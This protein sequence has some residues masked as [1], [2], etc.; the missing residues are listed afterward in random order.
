M[1]SPT[2][3]TDV[4]AGLR[5]SEE[6]FR[7][8]VQASSDMV[9]RMNPDWT[10]MHQLAGRD[11]IVNTD[12]PDRTWL[13]KY[14]HPDDQP[15]VM[16]G[17]EEAIRSKSVF[18]LVH[19][20]LRVDGSLGWT[21]SRAIPMLG[22]DG[23]IVEWIGMARDIT[24]RK[25]AKEASAR[26]RDLLQSVMNSAG[27]AHLVCLDLDF[28]FVR[29]NET[30]AAT[31]GYRPGEMV[32]KNHF[33]LYP[34]PE[35]EAIFRRVRDTGVPFQV[36]DKPFEFP[37]DPGRGVTYWDWTLTPLKDGGE[38]VTGLIL[39]L[40]ETTARVRA[41]AELKAMTETLEQRVAERTADLQVEI[42]QRHQAEIAL[43]ASEARL[44]TLFQ[45]SP[46]GVTLADPNHGR[47]LMVNPAY[48]GIV[49]YGEHELLGLPVGDITHPEDRAA[50]T[51]GFRQLVAG[52]IDVYARE[53]RYVRKDGGIV[54]VEVNVSLV[55]D[56]EGLPLHMVAMIADI[57]G[58]RKA[59]DALA[60]S[61]RLLQ[62]VIEHAP[63]RIFWKDRDSR[64][65]GCNVLFARDAG[66]ERPEDLVGKT[67]F[68]LAWR[69]Q[70]EGYRADDRAVMESGRAKLGYEELQDTPRGHTIWLRT[71]K[72]PLRNAEQGEV[73][74]ILGVYEDIT[75]RKALDARLAESTRRLAEERNFMDAV[76]DTQ[77]ALVLV[78]DADGRLVRFNQACA[79]LTGFDFDALRGSPDWWNMV[80][81]DERAGIEEHVLAVLRAGAVVVEHENHLLC[82]DGTRR[83]IYWRN[84][85]LRDGT[86]RLEYVIGTGIDITNLR[87]AEEAARE[88]LEDVSRLQRLQTA[89]EL[90]T[91]L[92]HEL[93]QPLAAIA[94]YAEVGRQLAGFPTPDPDKLADTLDRI[95]QQALRAG[96]IIRHLRRF[97]SRGQVD[98]LAMDLNEVIQRVCELMTPK[99]RRSGIDLKFL[100]DPGLA[101]VMGVE[102]QVEQVL[103]NLLLNALDAILD[104]GMRKGGVSVR[105]RR[106]GDKAQVT[107]SDTGPG[108]DNDAAARLFQPLA[109][110]KAHGLGVGLRISRS[111]IEANGGRLW[112]EPRVPGGMFHFELPLEPRA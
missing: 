51:E 112:V 29:V 25:E 36:H 88:H 45:L 9:Y 111:L 101:P 72:V 68:D 13:R 53:K 32:G 26:E 14:I 41:E 73:M 108:I 44:R 1:P 96:D 106:S 104:A 92:A 17:I 27:M 21:F 91:L 8:L 59:Q 93:N 99:A 10:E 22:P 19:R 31:C 47:L 61:R 24:D 80:P 84:T 94:T 16:A 11:F 56:A 78:V 86:G 30:Y 100:P 66:F 23:E 63:V 12:A 38:R 20:V 71:S 48:C 81:E 50:D 89:N 105:T 52:E 107:V 67:D 34:H 42:E 43:R 69:D 37:G 109:S 85:A 6:R 46:I 70:A 55:R 33:A 102:V 2:P 98:P 5:Q 75:E 79:A 87:Q 4:E 77:A 64:F 54:W 18:E 40:F 103:L 3:S 39:S 57:T 83:L 95:S 76:L 15:Q 60:E 97:V 28:N 49:G 90:A 7:A 62:S 74:G 58:R 35:N 82:G 110:R 65:L